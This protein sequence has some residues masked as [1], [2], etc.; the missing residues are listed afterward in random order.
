MGQNLLLLKPMEHYKLIKNSALV[1][2]YPDHQ[3]V[4][5]AMVIL[6]HLFP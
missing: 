5:K 3:I 1:K 2:D 6:G 4:I